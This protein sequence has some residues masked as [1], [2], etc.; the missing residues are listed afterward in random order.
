[1]LFAE[2][3]ANLL[4]AKANIIISSSLNLEVKHRLTVGE[5]EGECG[6]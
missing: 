6:V 4:K 3:K 5:R 1:L 2:A